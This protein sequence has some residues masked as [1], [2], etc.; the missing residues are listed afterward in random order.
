MEAENCTSNIE[1][2]A[3]ENSP[4]R[5]ERRPSTPRF[6]ACTLVSIVIAAFTLGCATS[7]G[8][9]V[10]AQPSVV[11]HDG[12]W[13]M[14]QNFPL[15][16]QT[17]NDDC[18]AAA[19]AAVV[20][21][22]GYSASAQSIEAALGRADNRLRAGD[23]E[24]YARSV[25]LGSYVFFGTMKDIVHELERGRPVIV[26]LGKMIEENKA[27]S[28]YEV[29]VGYE[30]QK[31]QLLLLDPARGFLV[32]SLDSFAK[33]WAVSKAI[34]IVAFPE[35][36]AVGSGDVEA[37]D[38]PRVASVAHDTALGSSAEQQS[39]AAREAASPEAQKYRAGDVIIISGATLLIILLVVLIIVLI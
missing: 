16:R 34:T 19:L 2:V 15:V 8:T 31:K 9:A 1:D 21:Y 22:W 12:Q 10:A 20:R 36:S 29:V 18:G 5:G 37:E 32:D 23:M 7:R 38:V 25:G 39:Y 27:V 3:S 11:A 4:R 6:V 17:G 26:G 28:H 13:K 24:A 35:T 33:E 14:V 30:P